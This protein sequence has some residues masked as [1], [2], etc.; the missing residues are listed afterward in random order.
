M[1][2]CRRFVVGQWSARQGSYCTRRPALF[3]NRLRP[4]NMGGSFAGETLFVWPP[5]AQARSQTVVL[6]PSSI[7]GTVLKHDT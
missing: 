4:G 1:T 3:A 6:Q 7:N 2:N 5:Y